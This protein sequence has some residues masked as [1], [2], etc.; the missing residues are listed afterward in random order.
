MEPNK[1][2]TKERALAVIKM[3]RKALEKAEEKIRMGVGE[4]LEEE[5]MI[6][7]SAL[8][9]NVVSIGI[10]ENNIVINCLR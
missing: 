6:V 9:E 3:G 4:N 7:L 10:K 2:P 1:I 5:G 8:T